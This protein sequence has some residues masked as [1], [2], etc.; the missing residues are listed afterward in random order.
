MAHIFVGGLIGVGSASK[1]EFISQHL[2][3]PEV[4]VASLQD[5]GAN[6][7]GLRD[8]PNVMCT[9]AIC[10]PLIAKLARPADRQHG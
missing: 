7:D 8:F 10:G 5:A 9:V 6:N 4:R 2:G 1:K 3:I